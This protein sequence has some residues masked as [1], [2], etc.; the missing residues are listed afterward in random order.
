MSQENSSRIVRNAFLTTI[1]AILMNPVSAVLGYYLNQTLQKPNLSIEY[2]S[3]TYVV[4]SHTLD[5]RVAKQLVNDH[6]L[7][8]RIRDALTILAASRGTESCVEW[9]NGGSWDDRCIP[10]VKE[11]ASG[12]MGS[13]KA[14]TSSAGPVAPGY[15]SSPTASRIKIDTLRN[16]LGEM[17]RME[18]NP[19]TNR[20]GTVS[21]PV[22]VLNT[23]DSAGIV[24]NRAHLRFEGRELWLSAEK[25]T[26]IKAQ[27]LEEIEF[28][29]PENEQ[30][31]VALKRWKELVKGGSQTPFEL[32]LKTA[33]A[34]IKKAATLSK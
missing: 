18:K 33:G 24:Y 30:D 12:L 11:V 4:D 34:P 8:S 23:G 29:I 14:G 27:S 25:Y 28:E 21:L 10:V 31:P 15:R 17:E 13:L 16:L 20:T 7:A 3:N 2:I 9:V 19:N 5:P 6:E 22:G 1:V 26:A 32:V